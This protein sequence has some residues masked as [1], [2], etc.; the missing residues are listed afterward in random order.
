VLFED[1]L[2]AQAEFLE[3][4]LGSVRFEGC[5]LTGADLRGAALEWHRIVEMADVWAAA[6]GIDVLDES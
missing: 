2:P 4:Q 6:R 3:A 1:R 5:D